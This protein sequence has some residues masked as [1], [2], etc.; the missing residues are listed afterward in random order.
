M[1]QKSAFKV[2]GNLDGKM[3][4]VPHISVAAGES[5]I[6]K[7]CEMAKI[8]YAV[9]YQSLRPSVRKSYLKNGEDLTAKVYDMSEIPYVN[10]RLCRFDAF[11]ELYTGKKGEIQLT[12]YCNTAR[13]N[14]DTTFVL[15]TRNY[16]LIAE[17]FKL[18]KCGGMHEKP[19]NLKIIRSTQ[20]VNDPVQAI[21]PGY[22]GVFNVVQKEYAEKNNITINCGMKDENGE[23]IGCARCPTGCYKP[24]VRVICYELAK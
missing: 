7:A 17:Y 2:Y 10:S 16:R 8:C 4:G 1:K 14:P 19:A 6:C 18:R 24:G 12:N 20:R 13:K 5:G 15:W 3:A 21:P 23:K 22:D 11:G 9:R